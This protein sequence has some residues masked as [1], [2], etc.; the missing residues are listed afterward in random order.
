MTEINSM[1]TEQ[2][3]SEAVRLDQEQKNGK[4][5][6]DAVK[7]ELQARGLQSIE[8]RNVKFIRYF[9][10]EGSASVV[11]SQS[12]DVIN[13]DR[14]RAVLSEGIW[15]SKVTE[16]TKTSYKYDKN[17]EKMLKAVF[18]GD[19]TFEYELEDFLDEMTEK[20][21][22]KQKKLLIKKLKGEYVADRKTLMS[23]FGHTENDVPDDYFDVELWFIYK[24]KNGELIRKFLPE[25][26]LDATIAEI[27][28]CLIVDSK[29]SITIDY[30]KK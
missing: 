25:E 20:P 11:D 19:Y 29:T 22:D 15:K 9:S 5:E 13:V 27:K 6:L 18:T 14:L 16:E 2:L 12:M 21:D 24:I 26:F 30:E 3:V 7:A 10:A 17:L 8:D 28:K 23:V 1:T 4:K